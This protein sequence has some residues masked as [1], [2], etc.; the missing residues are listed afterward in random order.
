MANRR[1]MAAG[2]NVMT[3]N[4][5]AHD[6]RQQKRA[7]EWEK[8]QQ[9]LMEARVKQAYD[10]DLLDYKHKQALELQQGRQTPEN[11]VNQAILEASQAPASTFEPQ[12]RAGLAQKLPPTEGPWTPGPEGSL[13]GS[14]QPLV[15]GQNY[16]PG[17]MQ[18]REAMLQAQLPAAIDKA[19]AAQ[20]A[21]LSRIGGLMQRPTRSASGA[22][23]TLQAARLQNQIQEVEQRNQI[24]PLVASQKYQANYPGPSMGVFGG[25]TDTKPNPL[26][27][28]LGTQQRPT[29]PAV[30]QTDTSGLRQQLDRM[31]MNPA[32]QATLEDLQ[33]G[34]ATPEEFLAREQEL[35]AQGVDTATIRRLLGL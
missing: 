8:F 9:R 11:Q 32:T 33:S 31:Q 21:Q 19:R 13:I 16:L 7:D 25:Y 35:A 6:E 27:A 5:V 26:Q 10:K 20:I 23:T 15:E 30:A 3:G 18:S 34:Q 2:L 17:A 14:Q 1:A 29:A 22:N 4:L 24:G 28:M 12:A